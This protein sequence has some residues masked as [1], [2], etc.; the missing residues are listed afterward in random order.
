ML[1]QLSAFHFLR[2]QWLWLLVPAVLLY[3]AFPEFVKDSGDDARNQVLV[4]G[5]GTEQGGPLRTASG[6]FLIENGRRIFSKLDLDGF[7][8]LKDQ[9]DIPISTVTL[10][11]TT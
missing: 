6:D 7:R 9:A 1:D 2:P 5:V 10:N 8:A 3:L 11:E 4:L